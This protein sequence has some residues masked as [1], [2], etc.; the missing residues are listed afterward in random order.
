MGETRSGTGLRLRMGLPLTGLAI[1]TLGIAA[2]ASPDNLEQIAADECRL[3]ECFVNEGVDEMFEGDFETEL[4]DLNRRTDEAGVSDLDVQ[5]A[6]EAMCP[7]VLE[8]FDA[9]LEEY[10]DER[11]PR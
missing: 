11:W 7:E 3:W 1:C 10:L 5:A 6:T 2:C 8:E 4:A 9:V